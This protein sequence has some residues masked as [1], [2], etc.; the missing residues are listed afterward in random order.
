LN[1]NLLDFT[2]IDDVVVPP[3][4]E[5]YVIVAW[6]DRVFPS[7][8]D[9]VDYNHDHTGFVPAG[10]SG[11]AGALWVNHEYVSFPF[12]ALFSAQA[13]LAGARTSFSEV[14]GFDLPI[15]KNRELFGEAAYN[16]GGSA[17]Q[18]RRGRRSPKKHTALGRY[19]HEN[20]ALRL[21]RRRRL[22][23]YMGDDRRG[24]HTWKFVSNR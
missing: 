14:I 10:G 1:P 15:T 6:G 20:I 9:Y 23:A 17:L 18:I 21:K 4:Y 19:R 7:K 13:N 16:T 3:E 8:H 22:I 12:S 24:G 11:S 2:V 5:R